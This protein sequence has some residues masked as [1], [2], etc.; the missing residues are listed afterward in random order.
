MAVVT[1]LDDYQGVALDSADWA[2]VTERFDVDV[3]K[4]HIADPAAVIERLRGSEIVVA[5]RERTAF[6][7]EVLRELPALKLLVTTGMKNAAIDLAAAA[8][9]GITVTG[10]SASG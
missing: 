10:T 5:M 1:V 6:P 2:P 4:E 3:V 8:E 7:A 9:C